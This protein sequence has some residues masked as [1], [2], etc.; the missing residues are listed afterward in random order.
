MK[1]RDVIDRVKRKVKPPRKNDVKTVV[2][3]TAGL[4]SA[5]WFALRL[6]KDLYGPGGTKLSRYNPSVDKSWPRDKS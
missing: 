3:V 1:P 4:G 5:I 6:R 2:A